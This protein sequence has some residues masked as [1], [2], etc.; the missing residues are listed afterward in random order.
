M[1][2][3]NYLYRPKVHAPKST[4]HNQQNQGQYPFA[5]TQNTKIPQE[6]CQPLMY[7]S[8]T[9]DN[10]LFPN[11]YNTNSPTGESTRDVSNYSATNVQNTQMTPWAYGM[12]YIPVVPPLQ[13]QNFPWM[14]HWPVSNVHFPNQL[15]VPQPVAV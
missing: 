8:S 11:V 2:L 13:S 5:R 3:A 14:Y 9:Y 10:P 1:N 12:P 15:Y 7:A 4:E 6:R